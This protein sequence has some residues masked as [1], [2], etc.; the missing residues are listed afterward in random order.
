MSNLTFITQIQTSR[1]LS[2]CVA[3]QHGQGPRE[4][5]VIDG[6]PMSGKTSATVTQKAWLEKIRCSV[7]CSLISETSESMA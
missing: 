4:R 3:P 2:A 1:A 5:S 7:V 6:I